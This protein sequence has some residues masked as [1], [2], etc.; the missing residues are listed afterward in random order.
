METDIS[1]RLVEL[2]KKQGYSQD[3]VSELL[4]VT[5]QAVSKWETGQGLP[6]AGNLVA[7]SEL[8][9]VTL[10]YLLKG[11]EPD[12]QPPVPAPRKMGPF[13]ILLL[14]LLGFA[15]VSL[16]GALFIFLL[17]YLTKSAYGG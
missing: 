11:E 14:A 3:K 1:N 6:D 15:G 5:R 7:L 16:I 9:G 4:N 13:K 12:V 8:Y 10:D 17:S 2:R